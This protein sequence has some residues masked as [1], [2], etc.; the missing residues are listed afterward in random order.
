MIEE[1]DID[2]VEDTA[3]TKLTKDLLVA[4]K[5]LQ[6]HEARFLVSAYYQMQKKRIT[7]SHQIRELKGDSA[8][9]G[10]LDWLESNNLFL[11]K[12]IQ[13][14][15]DK[16]SMSSPV[17]RWSRSI[18]GIGPVIAAGLLAHIDIE[19]APTAGHI[20]RFAGMDPT[21]KWD[22]GEKRP[23]NAGLKVL[24]YK[25][26]E[27]F[28]KAGGT[29]TDD[30]GDDDGTNDRYRLVFDARKAFETSNSDSGKHAAQAAVKATEVA[31]STDAWPWYNGC[32]PGG[33]YH[34]LKAVDEA[35]IRDFKPV[36]V[37]PKKNKAE[38]LRLRGEA[39]I[40]YLKDHRGAAGSGV[41]MLPPA[42]IHARARRYVAKMFIS[43]WHEIAF[44][45][46]FKTMPPAP[47]PLRCLSHLGH[48]HKIE[49][50]NQ[51]AAK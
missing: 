4:T 12:Q 37:D 38:L 36:D 14:A 31:K 27:S 20:W 18:R 22:K 15:L 40:L 7:A 45:D 23:W 50:P 33:T 3:V 9:H 29:G 49:P 5:E 11:E 6:P 19:K 30:A 10:I 1:P 34:A 8:P 24:L 47:Y 44:K 28:V 17:G 41:A 42:H 51:E 46:R 39:K 16:Y 32:Y 25:L 21:V 43:H 48:V 35:V 26:G 2:L 13:S